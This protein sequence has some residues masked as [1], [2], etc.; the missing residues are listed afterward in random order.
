MEGHG[1]GAEGHRRGVEGCRGGMEG[2][3][4]AQRGPLATIDL[5][6]DNREFEV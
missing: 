2:C 1:G 4:G 3:R 5:V 6:G